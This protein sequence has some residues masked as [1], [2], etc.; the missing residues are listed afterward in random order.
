MKRSIHDHEPEQ[1]IADE[2]QELLLGECDPFDLNNFIGGASE[3]LDKLKNTEPL[4]QALKHADLAV[5][6][7]I[8]MNA[9]ENHYHDLAEFFAEQ[10]YHNHELDHKYEE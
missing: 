8:V 2:V 7:Y 10:R 4:R 5:I 6:G 1:V 9:V 3:A